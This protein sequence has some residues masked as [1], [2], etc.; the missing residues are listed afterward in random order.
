MKGRRVILLLDISEPVE[1]G[2]VQNDFRLRRSLPTIL[3]LKKRGAK[4]III[5]HADK[6]VG[7]LKPIV[8]HLN[9]FVRVG[10]IPKVT[11]ALPLDAVKKLPDGGVMALENLRSVPGEEKNS[12]SL[13]RGIAKL[14][15]IFINDAFS[16]SHR[17]H[18]SVVRLPKLLP[19]YAGLL[20]EDEYKHLMRA[21]KPKKPFC[22]ILGGAKIETKIPLIKHYLPGAARVFIGGE[23]ANSFFKLKGYQIGRSALGGHVPGLSRL[24]K[25]K[26]IMLPEDVLLLSGKIARPDELSR[27]DEIV[28][29]GPKTIE[30]LKNCLKSAKSAL[31]NGPLGI[32]DRG[33]SKGTEEILKLLARSRAETVVG[34]G[35]TV[36]LVT[37]L[38]LERKFNFVSTGGGA[39]LQFLAEGTLPGIEALK[40][41]RN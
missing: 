23:P 31:F 13:A 6:S 4:T 30:T 12:L 25:D 24:L 14:G 9:R 32:Y 37:R 19:A 26:K 40:R 1:N 3:Y 22:F 21:R 27:S 34:G 36:V 10:F 7:S 2:V 5:S 39:M 41:Q 16:V 28:D 11:G 17:R 20:F 33:F 38:G 29:A 15:D 18:A 35:D 8:R